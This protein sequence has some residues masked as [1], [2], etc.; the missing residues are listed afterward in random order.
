MGTCPPAVNDLIAKFHEQADQ[1]RSPDYNETLVRIDFINPLFKALGWD[2]DNIAG[3]AEGYRDVVHEDAIRI[4]GNAKAPDYAFR[5][6]G[7]R[8]FFVEAKK[9]FVKLRDDPAP[10]Y[11]LRRYAWTAKLPLSVLTDFEEFVVYDTRVKPAWG[12]KASVARVNYL[13]CDEF[14]ARWEEVES[15]FSKE[16]ILKGNFDRYAEGK[17][18]RGTADFDDAFLEEI[19]TWRQEL[20][21]NVALRNESL[22]E[23][24]V[25]FTV[26]RIIDRIIFLRTCEA[27]GIETFGQL[28]ALL[29]G[30]QVYPRLNVVFR[31]ADA[32]Y[33]SGL[34]HFA[35]EPD[36][37]ETPDEFTP[38]LM[39]DD[40]VLRG[41]LKRL[42]YP[43][44]PYAFSAMAPEILGQVYEQFLGKVITLTAAHR[45]KVEEKPEVRKA[46]GV[47]YTPSYIVDYIVKHT[48]GDLLT[49]SPRTRGEGRGEGSELTPKEAAKLKVLDPACGSGSFLLGAYQ[50]LLDWHRNWYATHDPEKCA[51]G[52]SPRIRRVIALRAA[53]AHAT[54][55][56]ADAWALTI[57]ERKRILLDNIFGVDIDYQAVEVT[58]LSLL[59]KVLEGE[60]AETI[61]AQ[62]KLFHDRALPDLG[63]NIQ[64]GNSLIGTD[65]IAT[66]AW[67]KMSE[68]ERRRINPFDF[69]RA[70]PNIMQTGGGRRVALMR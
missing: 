9:P 57:A 20:A 38:G 22:S 56:P 49:P 11:Q 21:Q 1:Y 48:V 47:Y 28:Q 17:K 24:D 65:I 39:I 12:D 41:I 66:D 26:Q 50:Y 8:K 68:D 27:R 58:K 34:F 6:G 51:T 13:K 32:K 55:A 70:F 4:E 3:Y 43:E 62:A 63:R 60:N 16:S 10:A 61:G 18:K 45:A 53:E 64:C 36:R 23:H 15:L 44:S 67:R 42:Y 35:R 19:E 5:V 69:E 33:N 59:L 7:V 25:N 52:K 37:A 2:M 31:A 29:S 46:G 14:P 54:P 30:D 40:R